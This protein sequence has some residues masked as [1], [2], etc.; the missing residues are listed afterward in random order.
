MQSVADTHEIAVRF[1]S[2]VAGAG[3]VTIVQPAADA[4]GAMDA[5]A[6]VTTAMSQIRLMRSPVAVSTARP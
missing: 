5:I 2:E 3:A 1:P 6:T 4:A